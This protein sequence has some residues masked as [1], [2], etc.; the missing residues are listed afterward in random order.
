MEDDDLE[1]LK[2]L[3]LEECLEN[4]ELLEQ[5]L[6]R[7]SEGE[8][9]AETLNEVFRAAHSIKGG[10]A[11]FGYQPMS[12][13]THHMETLLDEMRSERRPV[14]ESDVDLLFTGL[15]IVQS[16]LED[17]RSGDAGDND[18]RLPIQKKLEETVAVAASAA[19]GDSSD[20]DNSADSVESNNEPV[21]FD[22]DLSFEP[23]KEFIKR[24][25]DP[26]LLLREVGRT[27]ELSLTPDLSGLPAIWDDYDPLEC[28]LSWQG[29]LLDGSPEA[30]IREI[31]EWVEDECVLNLDAIE[32]QPVN[33]VDAGNENLETRAAPSTT[34][35]DD[36]K[37][38]DNTA[39]AP[40]EA[41]KA[42]DN[43][44]STPPAAKAAKPNASSESSS[45]RIATDKID[46]L[47]NMVGE[48]VITQSMLSRVGDQAEPIDVQEL[49]ERL[50]DL[51]HHTRDL[52][53]SVMQVRMLP[54][55]SAF[56][57]LPRLVRDL[58]KK[59]DKD[60]DLVLEGGTTEL[61]KTVLERMIDPLVHLVRNSL[62][63]GLETPDE[64]VACNKSKTGKL[65]LTARQESG[66]VIIEIKDD[67]R[68][69]NCEKILGKAREKGIVHPDDDLSD[70]QINQLI[71]APGFSTAEQISDVSG[72]GV[73]MD[74]VRRNIVDLG[75]R[76]HV[77][78]KYGTG[79]TVEIKLPLSLAIL[80]GQLVRIANQ[81]FVIPILSIVETMELGQT[82]VSNVPGAGNVC[83]FRGVYL[84]TVDVARQFELNAPYESRMVVIVETHKQR[85]GLLVDDIL[86]QQQVVIKPLEKNYKPVEGL[87]GATIMSDGAVALILDPNGFKTDVPM[88]EAA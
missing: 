56:S 68:G 39:A 37:V 28:Y 18:G 29:N 76:V 46:Q 30:D 8:G 70:D 34:S 36:T 86:G 42:A 3:F 72:R 65:E 48:L 54:I 7:M 67:G 50:A 44:K 24:G 2:L 15:D 85:T 25:N 79:T 22:W 87:A 40:Q 69:I 6:M 35:E 5:G 77:H 58:S 75:G 45:I 1:E 14:V 71:F 49:R 63:H 66:N 82:E 21:S 47:I 84:P 9:D 33:S 74:V 11:S 38:V 57:R 20:G 62:D 73:G 51:E 78:S 17:S 61:D 41:Q 43:S 53:E 64:R 55:S 26:L 13:L 59:L 16:I 80:D 83:R 32:K 81:I 88:T 27:G 31:F 23:G 19:G 52:Q 60:V 12:E 10:A 4:I